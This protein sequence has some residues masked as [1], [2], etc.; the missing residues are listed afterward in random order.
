MCIF[1]GILV[2]S[3]LRVFYIL[4]VVRFKLACG[5]YTYKIVI[6]NSNNNYFNY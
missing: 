6:N 3:I 5:K 1:T 2:Y 4:K